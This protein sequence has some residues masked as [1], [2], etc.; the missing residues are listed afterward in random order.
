MTAPNEF[1]PARDSLAAYEL[2]CQLARDGHE[3]L[4]AWFC[5]QGRPGSAAAEAV[6]PADLGRCGVAPARVTT[7]P[8]QSDDYGEFLAGKAPRAQA[9]G[10][11]SVPAKTDA[12]ADA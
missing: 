8:A 7:K 10:L 1:S 6:Y 2:A 11:A 3:G 4:R 5:G 12:A 9:V